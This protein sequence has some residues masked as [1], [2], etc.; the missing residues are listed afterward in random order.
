MELALSHKLF[1]HHSMPDFAPQINWSM[2]NSSLSDCLAMNE[3]TP[4]PTSYR[5]V[6]TFL[7]TLDCQYWSIMGFDKD[8]N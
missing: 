7:T 6:C 8:G 1:S 2:V 3:I 5:W 4:P